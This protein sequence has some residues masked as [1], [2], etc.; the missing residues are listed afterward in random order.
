MLKQKIE[1]TDGLL[2]GGQTDGWMTDRLSCITAKQTD[3]LQ[4]QIFIYYGLTFHYEKYA[5]GN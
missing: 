5:G 4:T 3:K 1:G 2:N